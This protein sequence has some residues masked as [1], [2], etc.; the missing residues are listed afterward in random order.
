MVRL[1]LVK[2]V[3]DKMALETSLSATVR[4]FGPASL[5]L[6]VVSGQVKQSAIFSWLPIDLT[7]LSLGL[8]LLAMLHARSKL[9]KVSSSAVLPVVLW[10]LF[11]PAVTLYPVGISENNKVF[12]LYA[13]TLPVSLAP[14]F[15]L[16]SQE[17][18]RA[19][20]WALA[21]LSFLAVANGL[22]FNQSFADEYTSRLI[23]EGS[24]TIGS[25]RLA[26]SAAIVFLVLAVFRDLR[27][28]PRVAL[29]AGALIAVSF[30]LSTGS[31]G[32]VLAALAALAVTVVLAPA[33]R[34]FRFRALAVVS[35]ALAAAGSIAFALAEDGFIRIAGFLLGEE[36]TST[37]AR[38]QLWRNALD[39]I[40][41]SPFGSGWGYFDRVHG[42]HPHNIFLEVAAA[43]GV[44]IAGFFVL[45]FVLSLVR[46]IAA[47][48]TSTD[49]AYLALLVFSTFNS[50][51]S[52]DIN[53][54]RLLFVCL[55]A[56][57]AMP[58]LHP[59]R[60]TYE[61]YSMA[62]KHPQHPENASVEEQA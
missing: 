24:E 3:D 42:S 16:R 47:A 6:L 49:S 60:D 62:A 31:R 59:D 48:E 7:I 12:I 19:F 52:S 29:V 32:P 11:L 46:T 9:G 50:M 54:N 20:L 17:Q 5:A 15:V 33:F 36:D 39:V 23:L 37:R 22:V 2:P 57:W 10:L 61:G 14:F 55:F 51:V 1:V 53:G 44:I 25:S 21:G 45:F 13:V 40:G 28:I 58:R 30:A 38:E 35:V 56:A 41:Q 34:R 26:L 4:W 43:A 8:V 27:P 18:R